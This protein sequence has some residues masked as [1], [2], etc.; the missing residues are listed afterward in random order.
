MSQLPVYQLGQY[1]IKESGLAILSLR[2]VFACLLLYL[3]SWSL[4]SPLVAA[5]ARAKQ[6]HRIPC[7][8]CRFFTND[9]RL[10]CTV[11]PQVA[12]TEDAIGCR[13]YHDI[14]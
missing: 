1:A 5:V 10:K 14:S 6:M 3:C 12:N 4:I 7:T 2:F 8:K 11:K 13:D 9:H